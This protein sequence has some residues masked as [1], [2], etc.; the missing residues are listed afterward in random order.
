MNPWTE[1]NFLERLTP[2]LRR[3]NGSHP[4]ACPDVELLTAFADDQ[5]DRFVSDAVA[6]HL[7]RCSD[8]RELLE[9]IVNFASVSVPAQGVEWINTEK[10]L[11]IWMEGFL[12][13][14]P[15]KVRE[16]SL[17]QRP[18]DPEARGRRLSWWSLQW[19]LGAVAGAAVVAAAFLL[20]RP[21]Q[22]SPQRESQVALQTNRPADIPA[23][24]LIDGKPSESQGSSSAVSAG[25][26][27]VAG[28]PAGNT[29]PMV[30]TKSPASS[31]PAK[32]PVVPDKGESKAP[33]SALKSPPE[34]LQSTAQGGQNEVAQANPPADVRASNGEGNAASASTGS[35]P[36]AA[37]GSPSGGYV[38]GSKPL[39]MNGA[40]SPTMYGIAQET[41]S[42]PAPNANKAPAVGVEHLAPIHLD[43]GTRLW[44]RLSSVNRHPDGSFT[45]RG[46]LLQSVTY[47]GKV[48]LDQNVMVVGSGSKSNGRISVVVTELIA[49]G[50]SYKLRGGTRADIGQPGTGRA[51]EFDAG[52]VLE[53]WI[54]APSLYEN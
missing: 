22:P 8:C 6:A 40:K 12:R 48:P 21:G 46:S 49:Q 53:M 24:P 3:G 31:R 29:S 20:L 52:D 16:G 50:A 37:Q 11:D 44:I 38:A 26:E 5:L 43:A 51:V 47:A 39:G 15:G 4:D 1:E 18:L 7:E 25:S 27:K 13:T 10:R 32:Q 17:K 9:R 54:A 41:P 42:A 45:F 36:T 14:H 19:A 30:A 33:Q 35:Q 23:T 28:T 2:Q 34:P